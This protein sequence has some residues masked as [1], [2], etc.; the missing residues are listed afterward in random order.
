[1]AAD[2]TTAGFIPPASSD[3]Y[4]DALDDVLQ[5]AVVGITGIPGTLVRP[6]W[7]PSPPNQPAFDVDWC[8]VGITRK[9]VDS[10]AY[11]RHVPAGNA[12]AGQSIIERDE[13]LYV[14]HSFYGPNSSGLCERFRDGL[15]IQQNRD[16][17]AS[18]G[19][20]LVEVEEAV[21]LPALLQEK[22]VR[23]V[24]VTTIYRRRTGRAYNVSTIV[25]G[26]LGLD[27]ESYTT[28]ITVGNS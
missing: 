26:Q 23:R 7:Q 1:M 20:T 8:A 9:V 16:T 4:D 5:A 25:E 21:T 10:F 11:D 17:L 13:L 12:G 22:W 24:D 14:L 15:E 3:P 18:A 19:V 6:R 2:S 27:N 28:P